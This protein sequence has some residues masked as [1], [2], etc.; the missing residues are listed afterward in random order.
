MDLG[1]PLLEEGG[2]KRGVPLSPSLPPLCYVIKDL[3]RV[4]RATP[5][6]VEVKGTPWRWRASQEDKCSLAYY[7]QICYYDEN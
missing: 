2:K 7:S 3:G 1:R 5:F 4:D 6:I